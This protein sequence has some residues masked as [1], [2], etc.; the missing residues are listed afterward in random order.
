VKQ[1]NLLL[2]LLLAIISFP[3][4]ADDA[5]KLIK[6][7][8]KYYADNQIQRALDIYKPLAD[9]GNNKAIRRTA[10][11]FKKLNDPNNEIAYLGKAVGQPNISNT[12]LLY[13]GQALMKTGRYAEAKEWLIKYDSLVPGDSRGKILAAQCDNSLSLK[14]RENDFALYNLNI[15]TAKSQICPAYYKN[16]I[17]YSTFDERIMTEKKYMSNLNN[18]MDIY[19]ARQ[20]DAPYIFST[21]EILDNKINSPLHDGPGMFNNNESIFYFTRNNEEELNSKALQ[22]I[23]S[24]G[25]YESKIVS[26]NFSDPEPLDF[27][28]KVYS[29][30]HPTVS[31]NGRILVFTSDMGGGFGGKDLYYSTFIDSSGKWGRPVNMGPE[32][33]TSGNERYPFLHTDGTLYFTSDGHPSVGG[34]DIFKSLPVKGGVFEYGKAENAGR[35]V[36]SPYDD[37]G[38]VCDAEH[39]SGYFSSARPG[40]KGSDDIYFFTRGIVPLNVNLK[41]FEGKTVRYELRNVARNYNQ[42]V[43]KPNSEGRIILMLEPKTDYELNV[44]ADGKKVSQ[45]IITGE[46]NTEIELIMILP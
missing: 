10:D 2:A 25:I 20:T 40:G 16:G 5:D 6:K 22:G 15:N 45:S 36:N 14:V 3:I 13:Y 42:K 33:N 21:P 26:G 27:N 31:K 41:N 38:F 30:A 18:Y 37:F 28:G 34:M 35:P 44:F 39:T 29:V 19:Y 8:D 46:D 32:I 12:Y 23:I 4:I 9:A 1:K 7:A 24:L 17:I 43:G 11:C